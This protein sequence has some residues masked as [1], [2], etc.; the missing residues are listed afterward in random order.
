MDLYRTS[1]ALLFLRFGAQITLW[2]LV[3]HVRDDVMHASD[4]IDPDNVS[5][6]GVLMPVSRELGLPL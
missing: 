4:V 6:K 2:I 1:H 3:L 5:N